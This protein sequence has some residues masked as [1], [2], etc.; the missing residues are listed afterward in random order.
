MD[1]IL[2]LYFNETEELIEQILDDI[3]LLKNEPSADAINEILRKFHTIKGSSYSVGFKKIGDLAHKIEDFFVKI[4]DGKEELNDEIISN[5]ISV[6]ENLRNFIGTISSQELPQDSGLEIDFEIGEYDKDVHKPSVSSPE[7]SYSPAQTSYPLQTS[8]QVSDK[9]LIREQVKEKLSDKSLVDY[10]SDSEVFQLKRYIDEQRDL[11]LGFL[12]LSFDSEYDKE[13]KKAMQNI[14]DKGFEIISTITKIEGDFIIFCFIISPTRDD[15]NI[16]ELK[17]IIDVQK[18]LSSAKKGKSI[19]QPSKISLKVD[20]SEI[21]KIMNIIGDLVTIK[22]SIQVSMEPLFASFGIQHQELIQKIRDNMSEVE[23]K[24]RDIQD[25]VLEIRMFSL[26]DILK[27]VERDIISAA[28]E[29]GKKVEVKREGESISIDT[30]IARRLRNSLLHIAR[31]SVTHGIEPP[32]ERRKL[33]KNDV[34]KV[35][36]RTRR[37]G[38][39]IVTEITDDGKGIDPAHVVQKYL[40]WKQSNPILARKYDF[41]ETE[42]DFKLPD[43][44]WNKEKVFKLLFLPGF[45]TKDSADKGAGRGAGLYEVKREIEEAMGGRITIR[46]E[47]GEGTTFSIQIPTAKIVVETV[48]FQWKGKKYA[49]PL[50][51]ITKTEIFPENKDIIIKVLQGRKIAEISGREYPLLTL[52]EIFENRI[53]DLPERFYIFIV[54]SEEGKYS[55]IGLVADEI[56]DIR[57]SVMKNLDKNVL[58]LKGVSSVIEVIGEEG[59]KEIIP[60]IDVMRIPEFIS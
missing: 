5:L 13:G 23:R 48:I 32:E 15:A 57:D 24:I 40:A 49:L 6:V 47:L 4:R 27:F 38:R 60:V 59:K 11:Y 19:A 34:G 2:K 3:D 9:Q 56:L 39:Y 16:E 41:G 46:S 58:N 20:I 36:I 37:K 1:D 10:L 26:D 29:L 30:E 12:K 50:S 22:N 31:N 54:E 17:K 28:N 44:S 55:D 14:K 42:N 8:G 33:G 7:I 18:I 53:S 35:I 52:E 21:E 25:I 43:G 45:S 51:S